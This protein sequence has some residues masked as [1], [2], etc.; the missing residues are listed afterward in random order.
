ML[1]FY[2]GPPNHRTICIRPVRIPLNASL[3]SAFSAPNSSL[4]ETGI[5]LG[6]SSRKLC[7]LFESDQHRGGCISSLTLL[8]DYHS[9]SSQQIPIEAEGI[10]H[11]FNFIQRLAKACE[12]PVLLP[13]SKSCPAEVE[14]TKSNAE[15]ISSSSSNTSQVDQRNRLYTPFCSMLYGKA[16]SVGNKRKPTLS[17]LSLSLMDDETAKLY[18]CVFQGKFSSC[19]T[20]SSMADKNLD[21][22]ACSTT[23][24]SIENHFSSMHALKC[25]LTQSYG[26]HTHSMSNSRIISLTNTTM[27]VSLS[28]NDTVTLLWLPVNATSRFEAPCST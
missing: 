4:L 5:H 13:L 15:F 3:T 18:S 28:N 11:S 17:F 27:V 16:H 1:P 22:S 14:I 24:A 8:I 12:Y 6:N 2:P 20:M 10:F 19:L 26:T 23:A 21:H 9:G 25:S 7:S